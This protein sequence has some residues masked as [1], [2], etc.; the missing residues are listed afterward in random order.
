MKWLRGREELPAVLWISA[1]PI[2]KYWRPRAGPKATIPQR[3]GQGVRRSAVARWRR[4]PL[5]RYALDLVAWPGL[6]LARPADRFRG[7]DSP[8]VDHESMPES[9]DDVALAQRLV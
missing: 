3:S 8:D 6:D 9:S 4:K 2:H 5:D 1:P 7:S